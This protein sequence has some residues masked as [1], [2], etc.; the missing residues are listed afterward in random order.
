MTTFVPEVHKSFQLCLLQLDSTD[1][2]QLL[3]DLCGSLPPG[4]I[5]GFHR[6]RKT[7]KAVQ[8]VLSWGKNGILWGAKGLN[9]QGSELQPASSHVS[10]P[11]HAPCPL[12]ARAGRPSAHFC[13]CLWVCTA[14]H[15]LWEALLHLL[16][17]YL[18]PEGERCLP[19]PSACHSQS[20]QLS[21]DTSG[22][23]APKYNISQQDWSENNSE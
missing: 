10:H 6:S 22:K 13:F 1:P 8:K 2:L 11:H 4:D 9:S 18:L 20:W 23:F 16:T 7:P 3:Y 17:W 14:M 12:Q 21:D 15:L 5:L 19:H